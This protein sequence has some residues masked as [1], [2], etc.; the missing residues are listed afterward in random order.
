MARI[1]TVAARR[2]GW[3]VRLAYYFTRRTLAR[4][5][6]RSP[7]RVIE[8]LAVF[9]HVPPLL[10]AYGR[11]EQATARLHRLPTRLSDLA[12]LKAATVTRCEFCIDLGSQVARRR[13]G[14]SDAHL[15]ALPHHRT[16]LLFTD[17]EKLVMDYAAGMSRTP[18]DV[19]DGL[20]AK[21]RQHLDDAQMVELTFL[22]ALE[23]LRGRFNLAVGIGSA[24]F[25]D[26]MVC[27]LPDSD[28]AAA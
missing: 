9:A 20:F 15:L 19:P 13:S 21:L 23:N 4:L 24:G 2:A 11:L 28:G 26:G 14:V 5:T 25:S 6:G 8:P 3:G 22:I 7:E 16:S 12:E 27:A 17:L 1:P 10:Q 18:V